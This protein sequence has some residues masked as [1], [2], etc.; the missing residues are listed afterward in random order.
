MALAADL[1]AA[2]RGR[3][4]IRIVHV[5]VEGNPHSAFHT[6]APSHIV[7]ALRPPV[8]RGGECARRALR[9]PRA[10]RV[11]DDVWIAL[12]F[13]RV[14]PLD[15]VADF[16]GSATVGSGAYHHHSRLG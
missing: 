16:V 13:V 3:G 10:R 15:F 9:V 8:R 14:H 6:A 4:P 1:T 12:A 7:R 2:P 11:T 5:A